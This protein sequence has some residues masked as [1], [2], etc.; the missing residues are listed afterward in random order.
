MSLSLQLS[1]GLLAL[2][3]LIAFGTLGVLSDPTDC[4]AVPPSP[5]VLVVT[6]LAA[7]APP[8]VCEIGRRH[9]PALRLASAPA[10]LGRLT[11]RWGRDCRA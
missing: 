1:R 5:P 9:V 10:D 2:P 4:A 8:V 7:P 11:E 3:L 6:N